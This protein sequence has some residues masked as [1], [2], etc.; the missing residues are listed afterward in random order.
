[1]LEAFEA[2]QNNH[3]RIS[4]VQPLS[5]GDMFSSFYVVFFEV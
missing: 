3:G 2:T 1:M 4:E 5:I